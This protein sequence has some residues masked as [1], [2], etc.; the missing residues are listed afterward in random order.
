MSQDP[1]AQIFELMD[2]AQALPVGKSKL[3]VIEE[4]IRLADTHQF[5]NHGFYL[6]KSLLETA[7]FGGSPEK[8]M[9]AFAWCIAQ[10]DKD[11]DEYDPSEIL[12][13][14]KWIVGAL[15]QFPSISLEKLNQAS[16]DMERRYQEGGYGTGP[17]HKLRCMFE[18]FRGNREEAQKHQRLWKNASPGF[19]SDCPACER[20]D[21]IDYLLF[22]GKPERALEFAK[23]IL[24]N[25]QACA[26]VPHTTLGAVLMPL[27]QLGD[28]ERAAEY[29]LKGYRLVQEGRDFLTTIAEHL[30]FLA[31]TGNLD[32]GVRLVERHL[33]WAMECKTEARRYDFYQAARLLCLQLKAKKRDQLSLRLG[34]SFPRFQESGTYLVEDLQSWL[35]AETELLASRFD[36]RNQSDYFMKRY[37]NLH[38]LMHWSRDYPLKH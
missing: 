32:K 9:V 35:D 38:T 18:I 22:V 28:L 4:A 25:R 8:A 15:K 20:N 1:E 34:K 13:E 30:T 12:W 7:T 29:H 24:M 14:Y 16:D 6:R 27:L 5:T 33:E 3:A 31:L 19:M 21:K 2:K 23:P 10:C 26:E 11:P 36:A 37:E 17:I